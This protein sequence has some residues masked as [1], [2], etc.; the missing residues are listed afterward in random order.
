MKKPRARQEGSLTRFNWLHLTDL[1][2]GMP[3]QSALF[4]RV[5]EALF[6]DIEDIHEQSGPLDAVLF[7]G[8]LTFKGE[9][10]EFRTL[11]GEFLSALWDKLRQLGSEPQLLGIPGNHDLLRPASNR[12]EVILM[13]EWHQRPDEVADQFWQN[14]RCPYRQVVEE[15][16]SNYLSWWSNHPRR[17]VVCTGVLPG[18]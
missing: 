2:W 3:N 6:E 10:E 8:D 1:H 12:P 14:P 4:P 17:P 9:A 16:F 7:T 18:D 5:R 11:D 13:R 15:S